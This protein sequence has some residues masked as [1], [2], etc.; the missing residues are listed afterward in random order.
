[1]WLLLSCSC[2]SLWTKTL[3][4]LTQR[5]SLGPTW[6]SSQ[7]A[8]KTQCFSPSVSGWHA[9]KY[10]N[11]F[12]NEVSFVTVMKTRNAFVHNHE[13]ERNSMW[14]RFF[15]NFTLFSSFR[16]AADLSWRENRRDRA[17]IKWRFP[18]T[19]KYCTWKRPWDRN[20]CTESRLIHNMKINTQWSQAYWKM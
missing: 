5:Y 19:L 1:M 7:W 17:E 16:E 20:R 12:S 2:V 14:Q 3:S 4:I 6:V 15:L 11:V 8:C 9:L 10:L 18:L 13:K